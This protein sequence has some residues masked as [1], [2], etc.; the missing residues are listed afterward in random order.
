MISL[1]RALILV[2][3][4]LGSK[5]ER[6]VFEEAVRR[7]NGHKPRP[8]L[9]LKP[10]ALKLEITDEKES[11]TGQDL[12]LSLLLHSEHLQELSV[13]INAQA[14]R[15]TGVPDSL[16]YREEKDVLLQPK[17]G[18]CTGALERPQTVLSTGACFLWGGFQI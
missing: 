8:E 6:L 7:G 18:G 17:Q 10:P 12:E 14:M 1:P 2:L 13:Q 9:S 5:K 15:Y 16:V 11:I 3:F 4:L